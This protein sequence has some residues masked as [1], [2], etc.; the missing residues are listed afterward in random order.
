MSASKTSTMQTVRAV[1]EE[2]SSVIHV[3]R[4]QS[5]YCAHIMIARSAVL[6]TQEHSVQ[7]YCERSFLELLVR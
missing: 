2:V 1:P 7:D 4:M 3:V 6:P 5:I